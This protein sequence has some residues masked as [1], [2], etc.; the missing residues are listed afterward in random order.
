M[1]WA[2]NP[3]REWVA[4]PIT[5][6]PLSHQ[7]ACPPRPV[8]IA[9]CRIHSFIRLTL[10]V[11]SEAC[12]ATFGSVKRWPLE[13]SILVTSAWFLHVSWLKDMVSPVIGS[14]CLNVWGLL[15]LTEWELGRVN[16]FWHWAFLSGSQCCLVGEVSP[17]HRTIPLDPFSIYMHVYFTE[18]HIVHLLK[19]S[20]VSFVAP[21]FPPLPSSFP[22]T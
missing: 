13:I 22:H 2:L 19:K 16:P 17:H 15:D 14:C 7:W 3:P 1:K 20:L 12:T 5:W 11:S 9:A 18:P 8:I 21:V 10:F 4:N 6:V